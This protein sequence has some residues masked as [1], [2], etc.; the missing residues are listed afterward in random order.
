MRD[1]TARRVVVTGLGAVSSLGIGA[2]TFAAGIREG[3]SG[4][5]PIR[6]FDASGFPRT[7]AA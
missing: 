5:S 1:T 3:R 2:H 4:V 7:M 6:G